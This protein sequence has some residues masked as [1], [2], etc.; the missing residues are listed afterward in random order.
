MP[1]MAIPDALSSILKGKEN[2]LKAVSKLIEL[3]SGELHR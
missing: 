2:A 1:K 3:T